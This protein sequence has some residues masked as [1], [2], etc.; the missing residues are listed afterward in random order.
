METL[1]SPLFFCCSAVTL[2]VSA[3]PLP[4]WWWWWC[5]HSYRVAC[6][7]LWI[8]KEDTPADSR[9]PVQWPPVQSSNLIRRQ[10]FFLERLW[11]FSTLNSLQNYHQANRAGN[12][13]IC[14]SP[15]APLENSCP[16]L[17]PLLLFSSVQKVHLRFGFF[18]CP[19]LPPLWTR[20]GS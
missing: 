1:Y 14:P 11:S 16:L 18:F 2:T 15:I 17:W 8:T 13:V 12:F 7:L 3:H 4:W 5:C 19:I 20:G 9:A 6:I 10:D